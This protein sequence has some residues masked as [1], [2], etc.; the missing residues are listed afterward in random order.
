MLNMLCA[1]IV[2]DVVYYTPQFIADEVSSFN[3][4]HDDF[5]FH[6]EHHFW[7]I[8]PVVII[9]VKKTNSQL[10]FKCRLISHDKLQESSDYV[11]IV[12]TKKRLL[13]DESQFNFSN[14]FDESGLGTSAQKPTSKLSKRP[15][16]GCI[17]QKPTYQI[18]WKC[19]TPR[20]TKVSKH[21]HRMGDQGIAH[22][23]RE[24]TSERPIELLWKNSKIWPWIFRGIFIKY[25]FS[26][27]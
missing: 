21:K 1:I 7:F 6:V 13:S 3:A 8:Q 27:F 17:L 10:C 26:F 25:F 15:D 20:H 14:P 11:Y 9:R 16:A 19:H 22:C 2:V 18:C 4:S 12:K 24:I 5:F 23:G